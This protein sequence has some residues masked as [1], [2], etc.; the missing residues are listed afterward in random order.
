MADMGGYIGQ[1][2]VYQGRITGGAAENFS[3]GYG[4]GERVHTP[5]R[6]PLLEKLKCD[7][8]LACG[9][10]R[11]NRKYFL[12]SSFRHNKPTDKVLTFLIWCK[13]VS[14]V[15]TKRK[16]EKSILFTSMTT[17]PYYEN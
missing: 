8:I 3:D 15:V 14:E 6:S 12:C 9:T 2:D 13:E 5:T 16:I 7:G 4:L 1:F 17:P 11:G 10:S